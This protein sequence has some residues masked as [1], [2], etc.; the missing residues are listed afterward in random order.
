MKTQTRGAA[1]FIFWMLMGLL[2][3]AQ[4]I[5]GSVVDS[6]NKPVPFASVNLKGAGAIIIAYTTTN[7]QGNYALQIPANADRTNLQIG[8][9][10]IGFRKENMMVAN[11]TL[12]YNFRLHAAVQQLKTVTIRDKNPRLRVNGDTIS[13]KVADFAN[14]QDRV[15][16]DVIKKLPGIDVDKDGK[17]SYNGKAIS[18]VNIGGDNLLDDKY[19]IATNSIPHGV[20]DQ[21]QVME[22]H[23]PIKMLKDKVVSD[24]VALNLTIKKEAKL[25]VIGQET[26]G[27]GLPGNY[28]TDLNAMM[29]KDKYKAINGL[30]GNNVGTDVGNDLT[31]HNQAD[32]L[33]RLDND[34]PGT[35]L[36][37]GTAGDPDLP[38][39]RYLF[40]RA[41]LLNLNNL[42][43]LKKDV[44]L[45]ANLSYLH[46]EQRQ[47]YRKQSAIYLPNDTINYTENQY[48]KN[49]PDILHGQLLLNIN[50]SKYYLNNS[51]N[52][53]YSHTTGYSALTS[54]GVPLNQ[55]FK[56]NLTNIANE[57]NLMKTLKNN[58]IIELYSYF[59][60]TTEP[61]NRTIYPNLNPGIFNDGAAYN[62]LTQTANIPTWFTNNYVTY[63]IPTGAVT[64]SYKAGFTAQSQVLN[65]ALIASQLNNTT[66]LVSDSAK[67][68]LN[69]NRQKLY[70]E[71]DYDMPGRVWK[72]NVSLPLSLQ[73]THYTDAFFKLD[74]QLTRLYFDPRASVKFQ[75][76]IENY[77][78]AGYSYKNN[79]GNIQDVYR[80]YILTNYRSLLANN[81]YL[82]EK[83]LQNA[84][85]GFNFRK[86]ITLLFFSINAAYTHISADNI[87]SSI[88]TNNI[89]RRIVLP[90]KNNNIDSWTLSSNISKY[91][92]ALRTTFSAALNYQTTKLNQLQNNI[93]L[94]YITKS[95]GLT[96]AA[97]TKV[98]DK[99]NFSY[100]ANYTL[101]TSNSPAA[102]N[103]SKFQ[104][105][106]QTGSINYNPLPNFFTSIS[107]DYYYTHQQAANDL[108][109]VFADASL[110]YRFI[111]SKVDLEFTAQNI[112]NT[113]NYTAVYLAANVYTVSSYTIPG[114]IALAKVVFNL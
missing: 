56:D 3:R 63:R 90:Y 42:V 105:L 29:F 13:Y 53:D 99:V 19:N 82:S 7:E 76:G 44:Q 91:N 87:A 22:N 83:Q 54:N 43:N 28:Y 89:T 88:I 65:S 106:I 2:C 92:F 68:D 70:A 37:L 104:R 32:F 48:N 100:K 93:V 27:V 49:R 26:V 75:S 31:V 84:S 57:F 58:N 45:R 66:N 17:I 69:W 95:T 14:A 94:P 67:N 15:I 20:V 51:F 97:D 98:S 112:F 35:L 62:L 96:A 47:D 61:E 109:Y 46:D 38:R 9:T 101:T 6:L 80:G 73:N 114:R 86:A 81:T 107:G 41:G 24:D 71:A 34:R 72:I 33:S 23:Q 30:K 102:S 59:N 113:K 85:L 77:F 5:K 18:Q 60:R 64:Q 39:N 103:S 1:V 16:G 21:V 52:A 25:Q 79:I 36:S 111:K 40:N 108:K 55:L 74:E 78:T 50:K 10:S 11:L 4:T 12:P 8:V 110:R